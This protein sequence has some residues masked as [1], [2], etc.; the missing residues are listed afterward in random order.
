M[1]SC[2]H[3]TCFHPLTTSPPPLPLS[4]STS[5]PSSDKRVG[6]VRAGREW[7]RREWERGGGGGK[8]AKEAGM[9]QIKRGGEGC[10]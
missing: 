6:V 1:T 10:G 4:L 5:L 2:M 8:G 7:A 9:P 3:F